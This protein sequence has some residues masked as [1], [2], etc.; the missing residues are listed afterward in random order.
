MTTKRSKLW[1]SISAATFAGVAGLSACSTTGEGGEG[2]GEGE[3][4]QHAAHSTFGSEGEGEGEGSNDADLASD[5]LAYL[6]QLGLLRGHLLVGK[7]LHK[8]GHVSHAQT[9]MKHPESE[10]YAALAP[11]L[12]ARGSDGFKN[13]LLALTT[14]MSEEDKGV[15]DSAF[16]ELMAAVDE[17]QKLVAE[18]ALSPSA[19][20]KVAAKLLRT[21]GEEYAIAVVDGEMKNAHEYQDAFGFTEVAKTMVMN[22]SGLGQQ[23]A[24]A[25]EIFAGLTTMWPSLVPPE[26]LTTEAGQLYGAAAQLE[27]LALSL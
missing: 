11:A 25:A 26:T 10:L 21:A 18:D 8:A 7:E 27:L 19:T 9:H 22:L 3:Y 23:K 12:T 15:I 2:E 20:M 6:T 16:L 5:D 13:E 24:K 1:I 17:S 4:D 14:A